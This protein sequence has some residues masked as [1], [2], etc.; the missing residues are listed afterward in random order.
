MSTEWREQ[1]REESWGEGVVRTDNNFAADDIS[2]LAM[3]VR[4]AEVQAAAIVR[5]GTF[6]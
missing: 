5:G 1:G 6:C 4:E 3:S 2:N